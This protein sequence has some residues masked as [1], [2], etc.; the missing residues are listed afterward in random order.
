MANG[1]GDSKSRR[2][3]PTRQVGASN[4]TLEDLPKETDETSPS[5]APGKENAAA[6]YRS[7]VYLVGS[8]A[9]VGLMFAGVRYVLP[10]LNERVRQE[11]AVNR[12]ASARRAAVEREAARKEAAWK[13]FFH[14]SPRCVVEDN[15]TSVECVNEYI[16][17][18][19]DFD[20]RWDAG[21]L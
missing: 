11:H 15:Q 16:R 1:S 8:F 10:I 17:A 6:L 9:F 21:Q 5:D 3:D 14:R 20:R 13:D 12:D 18:K 19:R 7:L 2:I 4:L